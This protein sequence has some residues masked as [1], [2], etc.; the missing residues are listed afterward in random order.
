M[1][2]INMNTI[3]LHVHS[4]YSDG[5]D[6]PTELVR[7]AAAADLKAFALTDHDTTDGIDEA[8]N[9]GYAMG[10]EVIPG[11]EISTDYLDKE[12]HIVGLCIDHN[13]QSLRKALSD[14]LRKRDE[15]NHLMVERFNE[16]GFPVT[17]EE[18]IALFPNSVITRA[19]FA[20]YMVKKGYVESNKE[21]FDR[22]L[23][24]D[25]PLYVNRE[26]RSP[27]DA[28]RLIHDAGGA[29]IL[30]HPLLYHLT[31]GELKKLCTRLKDA[32]LTGIETMYS[33]YK[34]F[35]EI[36]VRKLARECGL[37]ESGGSDYHG[38]NKSHIQIG[39]GMGNLM[40]HYDYLS[41]IRDSII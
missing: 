33:T 38:A 15:R 7:K 5:T 3:D 20:S 16:A 17:M 9:A 31:Y 13:N 39:T 2:D 29:A 19:H 40:I 41:R 30:A 35:D 12:I 8:V 25:C 21:A 10:I 37:L 28:I 36:T 26:H 34:G 14:E 11:I 18:L 6:T 4:T 1:G 22:Y 23:G 27:E 32:G 24:D